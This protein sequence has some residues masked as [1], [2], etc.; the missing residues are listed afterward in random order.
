MWGHTTGLLET[1]K[2]SEKEGCLV[3]ATSAAK[4]RKAGGEGGYVFPS[5]VLEYGGWQDP[6]TSFSDSDF[7]LPLTLGLCRLEPQARSNQNENQNKV[8]V[9][10][11]QSVGGERIHGVG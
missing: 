3:L 8:L 10:I 1:G 6:P 5:S 4:P 9:S 2:E 11:L 7:D